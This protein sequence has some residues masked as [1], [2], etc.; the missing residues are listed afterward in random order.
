MK[1]TLTII[2]AILLVVIACMFGLPKY[3]VWTSK[4]AIETATNEGKASLAKAEEDRQIAIAEAQADLE[5][6]K[7]KSLAEVERAKGMAE[8]IEIENGK[9]TPLYIKYLWVRTNENSKGDKI[10]IP[11]EAQIPIMEAKSD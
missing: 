9:L 10:Y 7:L 1:V 6:Q 11:T 8:A 3:N 4:I 5:V 2:G